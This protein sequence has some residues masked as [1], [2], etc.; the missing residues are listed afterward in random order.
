MGD[1]EQIVLFRRTKPIKCEKAFYYANPQVFGS[2]MAS[3]SRP[4]KG[5]PIPTKN[6]PPKLDIA[7]MLNIMRGTKPDPIAHH[8]QLPDSKTIAQKDPKF[9]ETM[10][11][12]MD[13]SDEFMAQ[14]DLLN[15]EELQ[16][17]SQTQSSIDDDSDELD[18]ADISNFDADFVKQVAQLNEFDELF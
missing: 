4:A 15:D 16:K 12:S 2:R 3:L 11:K 6:Q 18:L 8:S 5:L 10:G 13:F 7:G 1:S 17:F 9:F 14:L